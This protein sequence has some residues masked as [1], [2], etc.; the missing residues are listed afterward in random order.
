MYPELGLSQFKWDYIPYQY[1]HTTNLKCLWLRDRCEP[2]K[3]CPLTPH[4][5]G[6]N[7]FW[8]TRSLFFNNKALQKDHCIMLVSSD[9]NR[10]QQQLGWSSGSQNLGTLLRKMK[11]GIATKESNALGPTDFRNLHWHKHPLTSTTYFKSTPERSAGRSE[12]KWK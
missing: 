8:P 4:L 2:I 6:D 5:H 7:L 1:R 12:N 11:T 3:L 10:S 9:C